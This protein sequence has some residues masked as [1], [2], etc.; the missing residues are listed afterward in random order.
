MNDAL[1]GATEVRMSVNGHPL[2]PA[3]TTFHGRAGQTVGTPAIDSTLARDV[4][5]TF[6]NVGGT[7]ATSGAQ[8]RPDLPAGTVVLGVTVEPLLAWLWIG[9]LIVGVGSALSFVRRR[10]AEEAP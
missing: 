1:R 7:G 5:V 6:L 3:I 2:A 10:H 9:G 4:Y 8:V